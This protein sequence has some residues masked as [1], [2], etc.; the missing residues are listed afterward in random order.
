[1]LSLMRKHA[2]SWLIKTF[3]AVIA[4]VFVFWG[5]GS[6]RE[7]RAARYAEVNGDGISASEVA[8]LYDN[9][10][11]QA[12]KQY[13]DFL[14]PELLQRL[15]LRKEA[16]NRLIEERLAI[17]EAV[18]LELGV[19]DDEVRA[20]L[21][22]YPM[23]QR[24]GRFDRDLYLRVLSANRIQPG[25]FEAQQKRALLIEKLRNTI[26]SMA[27]VGEA[28]AFDLWRLEKEK[29]VIDFVSFDPDRYLKDTT[30]D[31]KE[32][33]E[34][35]AK[36]NKAYEVPEQA[37]IGYINYL[38]AEFAKQIA[39]SP[40]EIQDYYNWHSEEFQQEKE[41]HARHILFKLA[42]DA[43]QEQVQSVRK[44]ALVVLDLAR[45]PNA[46]FEKLAIQYSEDTSAPKGGD[47]GFFK[48]GSMVK[49][50]EEAA[51]NMAPGEIS[52][53]VRTPF[54]LH[55]IKVE[56][57]K[58]PVVQPLD[59][60]K[61]QIEAKLKAEQANDVAFEA[62]D[63]DVEDAMQGR[64][65]REIAQ[66][67]GVQYV[68]S[69][70]FNESGPVPGLEKV[71]TAASSAFSLEIK[72][73]GPKLEAPNGYVVIQL[74]EKKPAAIPELDSIRGRVATD[75]KKEKADQLA[76][77]KAAEFIEIVAGGKDF[78][79]TAKEMNLE[80]KVGGPFNRSGAV[81]DLGINPKINMTVFAL[82]SPGDL[83][84]E[85][86]KNR[87]KLLV[88]RLKEKIKPDKQEFENEKKEF[89]DRMTTKQENDLFR[90]W[91]E[92][93]KDQAKIEIF[94]EI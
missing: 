1:M 19:T 94:Q 33:E 84:P 83:V 4:V 62:A 23:F 30:V 93:V 22:K 27:V 76:E 81:S 48:K 51:F 56:E 44:K 66:A 12:R 47:L 39:I 3:M 91:I 59:E 54:G 70:Y 63:N 50:F 72:E 75:L 82:N 14:T 37:R 13:R 21:Q 5:L 15:D 41:V 67:R 77:K 73:V 35:Y 7:R 24:D 46:D 6:F 18:R 31:D 57:V 65:L 74:L 42:E 34:Y 60:A 28:E 43:T 36:N 61:G 85:P 25:E 90:D 79:T 55:I 40:Q 38:Q 49:P 69:P 9:L 53:L 58:E 8:R 26:E 32:I 80:M 29:A 52:D 20:Q 92:A 88:V 89:M 17:Q 16:V 2:T 87:G 71:K 45:K 11:E 10:V 86:I 78:E 64:S 68:E